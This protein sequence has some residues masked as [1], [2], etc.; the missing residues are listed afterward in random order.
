MNNGSWPYSF[1]IIGHGVLGNSAISFWRIDA[2]EFKFPYY[3]F[4]LSDTMQLR[5]TTRT[6]YR[7]ELSPGRLI[8]RDF[9]NGVE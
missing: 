3:E 1:W 4:V 9:G 8:F 6:P 2:I 5:P 7:L